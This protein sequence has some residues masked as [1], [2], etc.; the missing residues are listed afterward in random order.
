MSTGNQEMGP[1]YNKQT[2]KQTV[3]I[4]NIFS[5]WADVDSEIPQGSLLRPVLFIIYIH[6]LTEYCDCGS[7]LYL[8]AD[9][10]KLFKHIK[11]EVDSQVLQDDLIKMKQEEEEEFIGWMDV[12]LLRLNVAKCNHVSYGEKT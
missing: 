3:R 7:E 4:N 6:D 1:Y 2:N 10:A 8:Y 5:D 9:D 12:W 11:N